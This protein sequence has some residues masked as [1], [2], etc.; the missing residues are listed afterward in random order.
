MKPRHAQHQRQSGVALLEVLIS[1][2]VFSFAILGIVALQ[3]RAI[4]FSGDADDRTRAALLANDIVST[5]WAQQ[6]TSATTLS[7]EIT[8]WQSRVSNSTS[9]L[10][11]GA[12]T[13]SAP[14]SDGVVTVSITWKAPYK[15]SADA[16]N[17]YMTQMVM[18]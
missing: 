4:Q 8:A 16:S 3:A 11:N 18:P 14:D 10:P 5:M 1:L 7:S 17:A 6:T 2:L 13:V 15:T 12:G 9:G